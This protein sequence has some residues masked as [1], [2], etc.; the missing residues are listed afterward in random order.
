MNTRVHQYTMYIFILERERITRILLDSKFSV[1]KLVTHAGSLCITV[2]SLFSGL[3]KVTA[4]R[5]EIV[6]HYICCKSSL[7]NL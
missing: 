1:F 7:T 2:N 3:I 4:I 5:Y 6:R